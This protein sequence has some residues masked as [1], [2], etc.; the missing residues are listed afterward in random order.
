MYFFYNLILI[1]LSL[2]LSPV[3]LIAFIVKPKFRAG[4]WQKIGFYKPSEISFKETKT[5]WIHAVSVGEVNAV[6]TFTKKL[7]NEYPDF[8]IVLST[9]TRTGQQVATN[10]LTNFTDKI[11]YFPYDFFFSVK[12]ALNIIKPDLVIIAETEI[13]PT[14]SNEVNKKNIPLMIINGRISPSSY[15]G[16]KRFKAIFSKILSNYSLIL[17]Q[18]KEDKDRIVDI[19]SNESKT[20]VMGNLKYDISANLS[21]EEIEVLSSS[22][23]TKG[24]TIL[25]AGST[26]AG[27]DEIVL[28]VFKQ[29]KSTHSNLKLLL[30]PRHPERNESVF[31]L[32]L[33]TG[34]NCGKRKSS[35]NFEQND[36]IMLDTMGE[37]GNIYS[38]AKIAFIGGSFSGTGG[39]N[40]LEAAIYNVPTISGPTIFNFKDVYKFLTQ[41][42]ASIIANNE[43]ELVE[44][45]EML[46]S[47][48]LKY[49]TCS[50]ACKTI[51]EQNSGALSYS[52]EKLKA[53]L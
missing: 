41:A 38:I 50:E 3:I 44:T 1:F 29:L 8:N 15:K 28:N 13:W 21:T 52:I 34:L 49:K 2:L 14:F 47:N 16:Y 40:P 42:K 25:I 11:I 12:S 24:K 7:R 22:L 46:L 27:E 36:I 48:D 35:D 33:K 20:E 4:F 23:K 10:K 45:L 19:G 17:M 5:I 30:A 37:L 18:S 6:E 39:H 9:V 26:H 43:K 53:F 32:M 51:F 31:E